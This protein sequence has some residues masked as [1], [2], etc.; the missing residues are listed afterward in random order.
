MG[1]PCF[2]EY[3]YAAQLRALIC[4]CTPA[5]SARWKEIESAMTEGIPIAAMVAD[6]ELQTKMVN[7]D[8]PWINMLLRT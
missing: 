3:C 4:L 6:M 5:F 8:N 2:Q 1:L 7:K